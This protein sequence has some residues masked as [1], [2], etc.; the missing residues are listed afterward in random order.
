[1]GRVVSRIPLLNWYAKHENANNN[2]LQHFF[3]W[4]TDPSGMYVQVFFEVLRYFV[5]HEYKV[6]HMGAVA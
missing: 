4:N 2:N 5:K 3:T 6:H 1:M